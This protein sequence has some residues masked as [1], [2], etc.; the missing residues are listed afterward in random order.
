MFFDGTRGKVIW[1]G[2]KRSDET[3]LFPF[4]KKIFGEKDWLLTEKNIIWYY[5]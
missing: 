1:F 3:L 5:Y 4:W 2:I